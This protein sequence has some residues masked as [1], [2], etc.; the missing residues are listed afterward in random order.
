MPYEVPALPYAF[1]ALEPHID[2]QT[3]QI[4][5]D[6]HHGAYVA[7]ANA[8]L[9]GTE[10]ANQPIEQ[11]LRD[12]GQ[13]PD[14]IRQGVINNGGGHANHS[15]FWQIMAPGKGGQPTGGIADGIKST[16]GTFDSF[17]ETFGNNAAT[18]F[19]SGWSWLVVDGDGKLQAYSTAN[20]D[21]PIMQGHTPILGL[22]VWEHAYYLKYQNRRPDY[23]SAWWNTINWDKVNE[24]LAGAAR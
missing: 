23:V 8:A 22:D 17:K 15:L 3:M 18:R 13:L 9:E 16:F 4:H 21:S 5:H 6:K 2:A 19:G 12:V 1:D 11:V 14:K 10:W 24:L 7:K 20:Q